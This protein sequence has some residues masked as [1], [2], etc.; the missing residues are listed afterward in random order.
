[1]NKDNLTNEHQYSQT[2]ALSGSRPSHLTMIP[3]AI[4]FILAPI[5]IVTNLPGIDIAIRTMIVVLMGL[6]ALIDLSELGIRHLQ[7][8]SGWMNK[9]RIIRACMKRQHI[10]SVVLTIL[11]IVG[12]FFLVQAPSQTVLAIC[13]YGYGV[14]WIAFSIKVCHECVCAPTES[15]ARQP[16]HL[17]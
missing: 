16:V 17:T 8:L 11:L 15:Y 5:A 3:V 13:M 10:I 4:A 1:M 7:K 2:H 9:Q 6:Y 14:I 12:S